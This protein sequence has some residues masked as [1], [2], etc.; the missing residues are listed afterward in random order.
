VPILYG[1]T[2]NELRLYVAYNNLFAPYWSVANITETD[3]ITKWIPGFYGADITPTMANAI[4]N[5]YFTPLGRNMTGGEVGSMV[6]DYAPHVGINNC[7]FRKTANTFSQLTTVY[8]WEFADP[9]AL[10]LGVGIA[11]GMDTHMEL[12]AVHSSELN[13]LFPNLSNT[14]A[15]NAPDL[16]PTSQQLAN[17]LVKTWGSFARTGSPQTNDIATWS[18]FSQVS[19]ANKVMR[20]ESP[21]NIGMYNADSRHQCSTFW[22]GQFPNLA[23]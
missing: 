21:T 1:G 17:I 6:S 16:N 2:E 13:Y 19:G 20:F 7:I 5:Q 14:A 15:I 9:N 3:L 10:V 22:E 18:I 11:P 23:Q 4:V 8:Q 12:G